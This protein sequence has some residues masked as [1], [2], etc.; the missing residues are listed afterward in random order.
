MRFALGLE[1]CLYANALDDICSARGSVELARKDGEGT[2]TE[3]L[4]EMTC[5]FQFFSGL[6][7]DKWGL[8]RS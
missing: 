1:G 6:D 7:S 2:F 3:S 4:R 5:F 8:V